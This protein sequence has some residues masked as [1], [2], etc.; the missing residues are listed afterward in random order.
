MRNRIL[1]YD[2]TFKGYI[3][4][5]KRISNLSGE[6]IIQGIPCPKE[7]QFIIDQQRK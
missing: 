7:F 2:K 5:T 3:K 6:L 4:A 1:A